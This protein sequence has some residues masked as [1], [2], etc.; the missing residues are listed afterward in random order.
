MPVKYTKQIEGEWFTPR[1][2]GWMLAC[3]DCGLVHRINFR[4]KN[5]QIQMQAF[6][7]DQAT[8]GKRRKQH[9]CRCKS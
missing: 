4:I 9:K 1:R 6:R 3:C 7:A 5:G 2:R 8:G